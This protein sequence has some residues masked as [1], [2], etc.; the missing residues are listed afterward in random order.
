MNVVWLKRDLRLHD[1]APLQAAIAAQKPFV[2]L[3]IYEPGLLQHADYDLRHWRF[4]HQSILDLNQQLTHHQ[5]P[6]VLACRGQAQSIFSQLHQIEPIETI[7]SHQ[8]IG[9]QWTFNR[10]LA[11][12]A[13]F[14]TQ[15]IKWQEFP[16]S[17]I[18]RGLKHRKGWKDHWLET[19]NQPIPPT[20]FSHWQAFDLSSLDRTQLMGAALP[21]S[22]WSETPDGWQVGGEQRAWQYIRSFAKDRGR[23]YMAN[24]SKPLSARRSCS[25]ISPYLAWGNISIRQAS[26]YLAREAKGI[27]ARNLQNIL[28]RLRWR[29]HF[30][31]KFES[32]CRIEFEN[33]NPAF[34]PIRTQLNE[35]YFEAWK[36]GQTGFPLVD[37]C[38]RCV[39]ET[40]YLNFRMRSMV[41]SFF[42]HALWQPWQPAAHYLAKM[43]LDYEPG[44]HYPQMQMQA[45]VTGIHTIRVYNPMVN[46]QKHDAE[47][48]FI[49]KWVPELSI[50]N[51]HQIHAPWE[52]PPLERQFIGFQLGDPYPHP[53]IDFK[54]AA[55]SANEQLWAIKNSTFA[56]R[57][58]KVIEA[59]HVNPGEPRQE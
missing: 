42:T 5:L 45:A 12:Q 20:D 39:K 6:P 24:I 48:D 47:G 36:A 29:D 17:G 53:I 52:I 35:E 33:F 11:L 41:V 2:L 7:F 22:G 50:L 9:V 16:F 19:I 34:D 49:R 1:H 3:Y 4:V 21:L 51:R 58:G 59:K 26:Q 18:K 54:K 55:Q 46:S 30:I 28:S 25:R 38:M 44:I 14:P 31:Q 8:E 23:A 27:G 40:G 37:A 57:Q 13:W 56:K 15:K 43:W 10:D 32:E